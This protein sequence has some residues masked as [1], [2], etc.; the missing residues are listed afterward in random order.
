[1]RSSYAALR[2]Q[3]LRGEPH[4]LGS[5]HPSR[6]DDRRINGDRNC[7]TAS[8]A[9]AFDKRNW[10]SDA[11]AGTAATSTGSEILIVGDFRTGYTIVDRINMKMEIIRNLC[12][13]T[14][15]FPTRQRG[16]YAFWRTG[17]NVVAPNAFRYLALK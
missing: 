12:G 2:Q 1:V 14:N 10:A 13:P 11:P 6:E 15:R 9:S 3:F 16:A 8:A 17:A 7:E 5:M 4:E